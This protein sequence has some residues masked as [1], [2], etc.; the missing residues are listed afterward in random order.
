MKNTLVTFLLVVCMIFFSTTATAQQYNESNDFSYALK[1]YNEGF[2]D[3]A[4]QQF[5]KFINRYPGSDRLPDAQFYYGE[6]LYKQKDFNDAR[7]EF[8]EVAVSYPEHKRAPE[9]W[10]MVG[11]CYQALNKPEQ[12]AKA[13][14]TVKILYPKNSLAPATLLSAAEMYMQVGQLT[15][16][17]QILQEF[18][19]RYLESSEYPRGRILYG[20]LLLK[21]GELERAS[22]EFQRVIAMEIADSLKANA[23]LGQAQVFRELGLLNRAISTLETIISQQPG[24]IAGFTAVRNLTAIFLAQRRV[25][26]ALALLDKQAAS[27]QQ[28]SQTDALTVLRSQAYF[29]KKDY[30]RASQLLQPM[31]HGTGDA[32]TLAKV[33]F[34]LACCLREENKTSEAISNFVEVEK[35]LAKGEGR[36]DL[37]AAT[38]I[39]LIDLSIDKGDF[40]QARQYLT[41]FQSLYPKKPEGEQRHRKLIEQAF[42]N[43]LLS[44]AM[45]ELQRYRGVYPNSPYR[46]DL[47]YR[48]GVAFFKNKQYERSLIQFEQITDEYVC[49]AQWDSS[50]AYIR[51]INTFYTR[52]QQT[53]VYELAKLMG[54]MLLGE[55]RSDLLF[56]LGQIYL[57]DLKDYREAARIFEQYVKDA[58][59]SSNAGKGLCY[60]SESYLKLADY[61][62]FLHQP[63]GDYREK[64]NKALKTAM[65]YLKFVPHPDTLMF[66]FLSRALSPDNTNPERF[67]KYW[68]H[69]EQI[70]AASPYLPLV[71][72]RLSD[73]VL[74][75]KDTAGAIRYL[76]EAIQ[77]AAG[78]MSVGRM[79]WKK[80]LLLAEQGKWTDAIETLK[81]FLLS[82]GKDPLQAKA[83]W[84]LGEW[85]RLKGD[86]VTAAQ[87]LERLLT[88]F[89][90]SDYALQAPLRI[91]D[92]YIQNGD[93]ER[94]LGFIQQQLAK[95]S[96]SQDVVASHY[97]A[98]PPPELYFYAGKAFYQQQHWQEARQNFLAYLTSNA[99]EDF[100]NEALLLLG[101]MAYEEKD[102]ESA[103]LHF[104]LVTPGQ[105]PAFYYE[106]NRLTAEI[107][108]NQ[109]KYKEAQEKYEKLISLAPDD[110]NKIFLASKRLLCLVYAGNSK[111]YQSQ[112]SIFKKTYK[113]HP[114]FK[115]YLAY[116]EF[117]RGK[118]QYENKHFDPAI[119]HFKKVLKRYK[120][121]DYADDARYYLARC[122][123]T[124]NRT[125]EALKELDTFLKDY[126]ESDLVGN[127]YLTRGEIYLRAEKT[128]EGLAAITKA[129]ELSKTP[130]TKQSAMALLINTYRSL[131]LWD[132][133]LQK[134][135]EYVREFPNA[136][137]VMNYRISIGVFLSRLNRFT[138]AIDYLRRLKFEVSS[139]QEPEIQFY[140]GEAYFNAGQYEDAINEFVKI[141]LLSQKTKLQWEASAFYYAGQSY[142]RLGRRQDAIRMYQEII[143]RP[144]I[145]IDFKREAKKLIDKL[146]RS[147]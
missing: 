13:Y 139:E 64:A 106:A 134:A 138:E 65:T 125:E 44:L 93:Y 15:R 47:I 90:Y 124:M 77:S 112:L 68:Q 61:Y 118:A 95:Y 38:L 137:D 43:N 8:Q 107:L 17:E 34:Y 33:R 9:A 12:A 42:A 66:R 147:N 75:V 89:N 46:D 101:K 109:K 27:Y 91:I 10:K 53:G 143:N 87:F 98:S 1:L 76:D 74:A 48:A 3:I 144:G 130:R 50:A 57:T 59:D 23:R 5:S 85:H 81:A 129:L 142:E 127:V 63:S 32:Q 84:Q 78:K 55:D 31:L 145:Q 113:K 14:E 122:Y 6:S 140:I 24:S 121:S 18:L 97:L 49:S 141:P 22:A 135:R 86:Y 30:S 114:R 80:S 99:P 29:L 71:K 54:R 123:A 67:L 58:P 79:Y 73:L 41:Q 111:G 88:Q 83:Y 25:D 11:K 28:P 116:L 92:D 62:E 7:I 126:P 110:D 19:D 36:D 69:F 100:H 146:A 128:D 70:Y 136:P 82:A 102:E 60:L 96:V 26:N 105:Q 21:K 132:G 120:K 45:D 40:Q 37:R 39:N 4:A 72:I 119:A 104:S 52:G 16:A 94:V 35:A 51:F 117:E 103:L 115:E 56:R 133:A 108:F 20:R 2:Y 131:G